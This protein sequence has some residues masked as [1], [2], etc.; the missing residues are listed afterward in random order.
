MVAFPDGERVAEI[1]A[2]DSIWLTWGTVLDA[3]RER[4]RREGANV[5]VATGGTR[6]P[7]GDGVLLFQLL[8]D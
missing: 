4:A 1:E 8:V 6:G 2:L 3:V 5:A 7:L